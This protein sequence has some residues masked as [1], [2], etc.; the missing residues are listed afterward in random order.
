L[1]LIALLFV[2]VVL[3]VVAI[4][5]FRVAPAY[6]EWYTVQKA[7]EGALTDT[8]DPSLNNIRTA[9]SRRLEA[10]YADA[11]ESKEVQVTRDGGRVTAYV[12]WQ[13]QLHLVGNASL[14]LD[15]EVTAT[16]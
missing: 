4:L 1:S 3:L 5:T 16:R 15:F 8:N 9:M 6:I 10:D 13:K 14:L 7:V 11:V 2:L 12:S